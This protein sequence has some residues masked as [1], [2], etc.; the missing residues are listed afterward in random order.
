MSDGQV[1]A[2]DRTDNER[3]I[4][5]QHRTIHPDDYSVAGLYERSLPL[6]S[7]YSLL[8]VYHLQ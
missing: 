6:L 8:L 3:K 5:Q 7:A 1:L 2:S 4:Y